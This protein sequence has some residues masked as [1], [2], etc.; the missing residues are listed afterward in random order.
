MCELDWLENYFSLITSPVELVFV[1]TGQV[2]VK[3]RLQWHDDQEI[4]NQA[5]IGEFGT[6]K[7]RRHLLEVNFLLPCQNHAAESLS[8]MCICLSSPTNVPAP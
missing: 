7:S 4:A 2:I 8:G 3:K 6:L 1:Q 5:I